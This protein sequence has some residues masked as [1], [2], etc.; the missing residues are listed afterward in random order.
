MMTETGGP[1]KKYIQPYFIDV[2]HDP[3]P[4]CSSQATRQTGGGLDTQESAEIL[5]GLYSRN[6]KRETIRQIKTSAQN[7]IS[8]FF[9]SV[10]TGPQLAAWHQKSLQ[11]SSG[12]ASTGE[13]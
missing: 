10:P 8:C 6:K 9:V 4:L 12:V 5:Q 11:R 2:I 3:R 13:H 1:M 7:L